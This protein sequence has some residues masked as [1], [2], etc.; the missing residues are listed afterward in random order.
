M[1]WRVTN[2]RWRRRVWL[3]AALFVACGCTAV[4][5]APDC[6]YSVVESGVAERSHPA[7]VAYLAGSRRGVRRALTDCSVFH[8]ASGWILKRACVPG[9]NVDDELRNIL[10]EKDLTRGRRYEALYLLARRTHDP[11]YACELLEWVRSPDNYVNVSG[12]DRLLALTKPGY[13]FSVGAKNP[14][15]IDPNEFRAFLEQ[16]G[17]A[18]D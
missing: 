3:I 17:W 8:D 18:E 11:N 13:Q 16:G 12:R 6:A 10:A 14:L 2:Q 9:L 1:P 15:T 5:C 7:L 4:V